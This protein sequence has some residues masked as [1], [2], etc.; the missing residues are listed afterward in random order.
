[1]EELGIENVKIESDLTVSLGVASVVPDHTMEPDEL[2]D[3]ADRALY[4]AKEEGRNKVIV[5]KQ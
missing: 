4:K 5:W 3:I 1:M 2:I